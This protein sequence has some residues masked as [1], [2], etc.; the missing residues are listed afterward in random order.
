MPGNVPKVDNDLL[1]E[2]AKRIAARRSKRKLTQAECAALADVSF[3]TW[4]KWESGKHAPAEAR[5]PVIAEVLKTSVGQLF[6]SKV[7]A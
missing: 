7:S 3:T 4:S 2:W 1:A 5:R 6:P